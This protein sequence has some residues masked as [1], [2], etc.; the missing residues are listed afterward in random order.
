MTNEQDLPNDQEL[1]L[2]TVSDDAAEA[3]MIEEMLRNNGIESVLQGDVNSVLPAGDLDDIQI[4]VKPADLGK[5]AELL[6]DYFTGE[7]SE[8]TPDESDSFPV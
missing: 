5:A 8:E 6:D 1:E 3:K 7:E 4:F 2:L